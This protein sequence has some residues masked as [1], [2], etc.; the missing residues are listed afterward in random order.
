MKKVLIPIIIFLLLIIGGLI[1]YFKIYDNSKATITLDINPSIEIKINEEDKVSKVKVLNNDGKDII[2]ND[3]VGKPFSEVIKT[4]SNN[5]IDKG[6]VPYDDYV[7]IIM[8]TEGE[9]DK[10]ELGIRIHEP[11]DAKEIGIDII[12]VETITKEDEKLA[13]KYDIS[14]AKAAYINSIK[15][16]ND[17]VSIEEIVNKSA[18]EL[19]ET[20]EKGMYCDNGYTLRGDFCEKEVER[21]KAKEGMV[22]P[23]GYYEYNGSCYEETGTIDTDKLVCRDELKLVD[24]KCI[25]EGLLD[26]VPIYHCDKGELYKKGD[27]FSV[28]GI[29]DRDKYFCV[30]KSTGK[31][32]T[33][34]CLLNK[35][36]IMING[37]CYNGPAPTI[38][39]GCPN[40]DTLRGGGCYS[41]DNED[42][43]ECP[44]GNIYMKSKE[45]IP[46][47]CPDTF[48]YMEPTIEGYKCEEEDYE[49]EDNKCV[50]REIDD[51]YYEKACPEGYKMVDDQKCI[52]DNTKDKIDGY[53]CEDNYRLER[54]ECVRYEEIPAK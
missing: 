2:S 50:K 13:K 43:W 21:I 27:L 52:N 8:H 37:R 31:E 49:L 14:P 33:L 39:G 11:F 34:R 41:L 28:G 1:Y 53:Y 19:K 36:H 18:N 44:D 46:E 24:G 48:T 35:N 40:G 47:L 12:D 5:I 23:K 6:Y 20:K 30:D 15:K 10:E 9:V 17:N 4:I 3:M 51:P 29:K 26:A 32:P 16:D 42:Q 45:T 22:C 25:K 54:D 38:N 7:V